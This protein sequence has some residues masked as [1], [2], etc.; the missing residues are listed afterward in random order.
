MT[1]K[2]VVLITGG[3]GFLGGRLGQYLSDNYNVILGSRSNQSMPNWLPSAKVS[4][5][6]WSSYQSLNDACRSV[7]II[8]HASGLNAQECG[9]NPEKAL[10]VNGVYTQNLVEVAV[11]QG[12]KKI[13]YLSTVHVYSDCLTGTISE[14]A[15]TLNTHP[16]AT[17]HV[18]GENSVLSAIKQGGLDGFVVRIANIFGTPVS[19]EVN[20]WMLLINELCKQAVSEKSLVLY[21]SRKTVR[22]FVTISDFCSAIGFLIENNQT[23]SIVN[24]GSG[25]GCSIDKMASRVQDNCLTVLGFKPPIVF[26]NKSTERQLPLNLQTDHLDN[27]GFKFVN[28]FDAEIKELILFCKK[29]FG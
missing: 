27:V 4:K 17:S 25:K 5:I 15:A 18:V 7:D 12:V 6:D 23:E 3:F 22:D 21:S 1:I 26:G 28:D 2:K 19:K 13:I 11:N 14:D 10:L 16:Y 8:I 20:C 9:E 24:I 29:E